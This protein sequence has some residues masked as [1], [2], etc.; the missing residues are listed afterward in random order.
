MSTSPHAYP[1]LCFDVQAEKAM[2]QVLAYPRSAKAWV[3]ASLTS[4]V[5][6]VP[7]EFALILHLLLHF[8]SAT[9]THRMT[10]AAL[11]KKIIY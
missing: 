5:P 1:D 7:S 4:P 6:R 9:Y 11:Q 10:S 3:S 2:M 8:G